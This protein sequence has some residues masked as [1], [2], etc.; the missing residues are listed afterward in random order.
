MHIAH[1]QNAELI[2]VKELAKKVGLKR[3]QI[4]H[5]ARNR[6][7]PDAIQRDG[8]HY[9]YPV[10]P[11]LR[12]W[13]EWKRRKVQQRKQPSKTAKVNLTTGVITVPGIRQEFD[14][15]YRRVGELDGILK[16]P[17]KCRN[18]IAI[19]LR[20]IARLYSQLANQGFRTGH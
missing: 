19:E 12:D 6:K 5:L 13:I 17:S 20:P 16:M 10:T 15:W 11:E 1:V 3:R 4:A 14:I 7:I 2:G 9:V 18:D 8:Y